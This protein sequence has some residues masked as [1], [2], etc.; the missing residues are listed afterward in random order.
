MLPTLPNPCTATR[1]PASGIPRWRAVSRVAI[2]TP[3]PVASIRPAEPPM[4][5][6]LPVTTAGTE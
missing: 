3:R 6:G 2:E 5:I 4:E 1:A